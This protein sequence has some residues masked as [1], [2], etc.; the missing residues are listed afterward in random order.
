VGEHYDERIVPFRCVE[1]LAMRLLDATGAVELAAHRIADQLARDGLILVRRTSVEAV[2]ALL[3]G[4]TAP[5]GHPDDHETGVTHI[6]PH[7]CRAPRAGG[8]GFTR[9]VLPPHTDRSLQPEPPS[10]LAAV[11]VAPATSG[12]EALLA[13]G[14][15]VLTLMRRRWSPA[16]TD[17]LR[18]QTA[19]GAAVPVVATRG[20]LLRIRFRDD[21]LATPYSDANPADV[22]ALRDS[23]T[24]MTRSIPLRAG[25]GYIIHNH[26]Y[27]HGRSSFR[28]HRTLAR[29]HATVTCPR[30]AW[31]NE[32]FQGASS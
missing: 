26:R 20:C 16:V 30:L 8:A 4:W 12:G 1:D 10:V 11:M 19:D 7:G 27:L 6:S 14:A 23:I 5:V 31:L 29:M 32:G 3:A 25:D 21:E 24:A 9:A 15:A 18:L 17:R 2:R 22:G 28:G 13:D